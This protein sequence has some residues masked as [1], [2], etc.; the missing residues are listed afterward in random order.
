MPVLA[1]DLCRT[2]VSAGFAVLWLRE[3]PVSDE[4]R[5]FQDRCR[6]LL[7]GGKVRNRL[8][9]AEFL[10]FFDTLGL[11]LLLPRVVTLSIPL[12]VADG[13][14]LLHSPVVGDVRILPRAPGIRQQQNNRQD[15]QDD[16]NEEPF[17]HGGSSRFGRVIGACRRWQRA[18]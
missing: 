7:L 15:D 17:G 6:I 11:S 9:L 1:V 10:A 3:A 13:L 12:P 8:V 16:C 18:A 5:L 2:A 4:Q 14:P